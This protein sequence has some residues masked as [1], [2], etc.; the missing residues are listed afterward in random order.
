MSLHE[1]D[2][3]KIEQLCPELKSI[4]DAELAAGNEVLAF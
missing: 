4:L 2:A 3:H 1:I